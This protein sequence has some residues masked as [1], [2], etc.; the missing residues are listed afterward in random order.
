LPV[1][2]EP[3]VGAAVAALEP[4]RWAACGRTAGARPGG[5]AQVMLGPGTAIVLGA[6]NLSEPERLHHPALLG[7]PASDSTAH[8]TL[9]ALDEP[10]LESP[11]PSPLARVG[12]AAPAAGRFSPG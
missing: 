3:L 1:L 5:G 9:A 4:L 6:K 11:R 10:Q 12:P 7:A 8:R 2:A